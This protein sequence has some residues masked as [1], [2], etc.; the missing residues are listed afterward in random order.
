MNKIEL[1]VHTHTLASGHAYGTILEM[2]SAAGEM[3]LKL[4]GITEHAA[5]IPGTCCDL[6]FKN[7]A[8]VPRV[9][10]GV[11]LLLGTEVNILDYEGTLSMDKALL[12]KMDI[13]IAGIH[14]E[15]YTH[16]TKAQNTAATISAITNPLVD[17]ISHPVDGNCPLD[18][19]AVAKAARDHHV[20]LEVNNHA[21][22]GPRLK[23]PG[24]NTLEMLKWCKKLDLPV[25]M[26]SDAHHMCDIANFDHAIPILKE[27]GYPDELVINYSADAFLKFIRENRSREEA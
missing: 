24:K 26:G 8:V 13:R 20:L 21:L 16:G 12:Q 10:K 7:L 25:I 27:A 11:P 5:G 15:C 19:E 4:L 9:Q 14:A 17:I 18:Y 22:R 23:D 2:A 3:G 6:Y 1:D